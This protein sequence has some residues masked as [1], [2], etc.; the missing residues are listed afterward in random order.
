VFVALTTLVGVAPS[1]PA[2]AAPAEQH[3]VVRVVGTAASGELLTSRPSCYAT[4]DAA[5]AAVGMDSAAGSGG[6]RRPSRAAMTASS[7]IGIHY[8]G[9]NWTGSSTTV[10]GDNCAG[11]WLNVSATWNNR[12]SSTLHGCPRIKHFDGSN[13]TGTAETTFDPGGN[14]TTLNNR[15][16][17]IQYLT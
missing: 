3:C 5:M 6:D 8:D 16:T 17:S 4:F 15:T 11:G 10:V 14:L 1:P 7:T 9:F 13:L 2:N 12:I